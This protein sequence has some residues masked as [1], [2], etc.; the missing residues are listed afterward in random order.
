M[1]SNLCAGNN[2]PVI[3]KKS[4]NSFENFG[5]KEKDF[6]EKKWGSARIGGLAPNSGWTPILFGRHKN[7]YLC[8]S[9]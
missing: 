8:S 9:S 5:K 1:I 3:G 7:C 6:K 4:W 2:V